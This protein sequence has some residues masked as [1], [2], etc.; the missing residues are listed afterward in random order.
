[1]KLKLFSLTFV[2]FV[3]G[4]CMVE[5]DYKRPN[6]NVAERFKEAP[7]GWKFARPA[8]TV[9]RGQWWRIWRDE[10]L[11]DLAVQVAQENQTV[12]RAWANYR[13]ARAKIQSARADFFPQ[14]GL[15]AGIS[16]NESSSDSKK[17]LTLD[18]GWEIDFWGKTARN[19]EAA[20]ASSEAQAA[21]L[22]AAQLSQEAELVQNYFALRVLDQRKHLTRETIKLYERTLTITQN[23]YKVGLVAK[24]DVMSAQAQLKSAQAQLLELEL[25]RRQYEHAIAIL[26]GKAP[27]EF[28]LAENLNWKPYYPQIPASLPSDLQERRPDIAQAERQMIAANAKIGVAKAAFYPNISLSASGGYKAVHLAD[29]FNV[30]SRVWSVGAALTE[31]L[32]DAGRRRAGVNSAQAVYDA[33]EA[34]YRQTV[35]NALQEV[36]DNLAAVTILAQERKLQTESLNAATESSRIALNQYRAGTKIFTTVSS[37]QITQYNT[38]QN[39]W[40]LSARQLSGQVLLIKALG[41]LW[42]TDTETTQ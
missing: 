1:M 7:A 38:E 10:T 28:A 2:V 11:N 39:V 42:Q 22:A 33:S 41:G 12:A 18:A 25:S 17:S 3:L 20:N 30:P 35:L 24:S 26:I 6:V 21:A 29:L 14:V 40:Q 5:P 4:G 32:F 27:A 36:E 31:P 9:N 8:D 13:E 19:V 15:G 34:T 37:A 16:R 23:Q